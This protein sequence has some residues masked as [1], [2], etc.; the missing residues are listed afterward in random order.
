MGKTI[1]AVMFRGESLVKESLSSHY[2]KTVGSKNRLSV[3]GYV[4]IGIESSGF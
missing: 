4:H 1:S 3:D 2:S